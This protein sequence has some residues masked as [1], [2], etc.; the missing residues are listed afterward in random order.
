MR[1]ELR[2]VAAGLVAAGLLSFTTLP[3]QAAEVEFVVQT[4]NHAHATT[5][6]EK[7]Q[8]AG[9]AATLNPWAPA[10]I[11]PAI[12]WFVPVAETGLGVA[13]IVGLFTRLA[14]FA[15]GVLEQLSRDQLRQLFVASRMTSFDGIDGEARDPDAW[16]KVF[17][18]KVRDIREGGPC[19][20]TQKSRA[21]SQQ[22]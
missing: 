9:Y 14:A 19:P 3:A 17:Q 13:L 16:V 7:L 6:V 11:V 20:P 5:L 18:D 15:S 22:P 1:S 10:S 2:S 4:R 21:N 8:A 12:V